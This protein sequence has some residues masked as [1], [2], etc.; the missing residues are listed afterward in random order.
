MKSV[1]KTPKSWI[2]EIRAAQLDA[3]EAIPFGPMVGADIPVHDLFHLAPVTALKFRRLPM[4]R[5]NLKRAMD[6]A[7]VSHV[8]TVTNSP[9]LTSFPTVCFAFA[10]LAS[11]Y[12]LNLITEE[13]A[14]LVMTE[15][16]ENPEQLLAPTTP[17]RARRPA[18]PRRTSPGI[19]RLK[20]AAKVLLPKRRRRV[21]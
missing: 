16:A 21:A 9:Q 10:Y 3:A 7:M 13:Q 20:S 4:T 8:A 15:I 2:T 18:L 1:P 6:A 14:N 11:H 17:A 19:R 12:G 5:R